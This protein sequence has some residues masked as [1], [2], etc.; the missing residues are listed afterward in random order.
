MNSWQGLQFEILMLNF[1]LMLS[2]PSLPFMTIDR[3]PR[4]ALQT[5]RFFAG[6]AD[7]FIPLAGKWPYLPGVPRVARR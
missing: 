2:L 1:I 4:A 6:R 7:V 3:H 5:L